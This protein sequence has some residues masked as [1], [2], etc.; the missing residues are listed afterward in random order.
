MALTLV[1]LSSVAAAGLLEAGARAAREA[2][3]REHLLWAA[4]SILD[5]LRNAPGWSGGERVL[6]D[7]ARLRWVRD[8]S[9]GRLEAA[10][11]GSAEPWIVLPVGSPGVEP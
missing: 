10:L 8:A 2:E 4:G 1:A 11:A 9:Q 3:S 7:G 6:P 5:S